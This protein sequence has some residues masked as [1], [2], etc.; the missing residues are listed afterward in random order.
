MNIREAKEQVKYTVKSYL[1]RNELGEYVIPIERQRPVFLMGPPG[2]G[3]TA[4]MSQVAS[5]LGLALVSYSMTHH[6]RQSALGLPFIADK[7]YGGQ[8][9]RVSEYTMSEII[10]SMYEEMEKTGKKEGILFLDEINC[11]SETLAPSMLQ[12]LQFKTFGMHRIPDG[13]IVITA[14][15]PPEYNNSVREFDIVTWDRLKRVDIE[16]DFGAWKEYAYEAKVHP[17]ITTYLSI[18]NQDFYLVQTTVDGK[19]FVTARGW[20]DLSDIIYLYEKNE[21]PV[22]AELVRQYLQNSR[23]AEEFAIYYDLYN[24]YKSD[25]QIDKILSGDIS[26]EIVERARLARFDERL[27][28]IGLLLEHVGNRFYE[29][30]DKEKTMRIVVQEL[31]GLKNTITDGSAEQGFTVLGNAV[32]KLRLSSAKGVKSRTATE[33]DSLDRYRAANTMER[34]LAAARVAD[35]VDGE[36]LYTHLQTEFRKENDSLKALAAKT[37]EALSNL[38]KFSETA[39]D[40]G[41]EMLVIVTELTTNL[42]S[43]SFIS[44]YGCKE[45]FDHNQEL[46]FYERQ[47]ELSRDLEELG[48]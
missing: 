42:Y 18:K 7:V 37:G 34:L 22:T 40:D 17:A 43:S 9:V 19:T 2:I 1:T 39:F 20:E 5:E 15:N 16:P 6:T 24:K 8:N 3:K 28:V 26:E 46:M 48:L 33:E 41:N 12:F 21:F 13:W 47:K 45:Y 14:G 30:Y 38:F 25:Y 4:I 23:I 36:E 35:P 31:K 32:D 44:R 11:V 27:T 10:S 29:V